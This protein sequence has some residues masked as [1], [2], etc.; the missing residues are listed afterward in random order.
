MYKSFGLWGSFENYS[1]YDVVGKDLSKAK[2]IAK[3]I[4]ESDKYET[5]YVFYVKNDNKIERVMLVTFP[6]IISEIGIPEES[7]HMLDWDEGFEFLIKNLNFNVSSYDLEKFISILMNNNPDADKTLLHGLPEYIEKMGI[8]DFFLDMK[9]YVWGG[10]YGTGLPGIE[11]KLPDIN[12]DN[13]VAITRDGVPT[14]VNINLHLYK[15]Q[16]FGGGEEIYIYDGQPR[17]LNSITYAEILDF[18]TIIYKKEIEDEHFKTPDFSNSGFIT[19]YT[20]KAYRDEIYDLEKDPEERV[21]RFIKG[22]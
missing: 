9:R 3:K 22:K 8:Y 17:Y 6:Y 18:V 11:L 12:A 7:L 21:R 19:D 16:S 14:Y 13:N 10:I 15:T 1:F 2:E 20:L 4:V 5:A